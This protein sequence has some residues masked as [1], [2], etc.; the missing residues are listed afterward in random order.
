MT[1]TSPISVDIADGVAHVRLIR[2]DKLNAMNKAFWRDLPA[3]IRNI[4]DNARARVIVISSEGKH[5]SSGMDL[6]VFAEDPALNAPATGDTTVGNE[7]FR[8]LVA[9]LQDSFSALDEAR[10]PVLAAIQGGCIGGAV[11]MVSACD[12]RYATADAF[13]QIHEINIGMTADVGTFPRLCKLLPDGALRELAYTGRRLGAQKALALG[14]VTEVYPDQATMLEA[15]MATAREIASKAPLAIAGTKMMINYARDHTIA[16]GLD[17]IALWQA[18][19]HSRAAM[20]EAF[21]AQQDKR[22][23]VYPDLAPLR[24]EL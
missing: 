21:R 14:L 3:L 13:F 11:D 5:F 7:A 9:L 20:A 16:E 8:H 15:V 17:R 18:G 10:M 24:K 22:T 4:S 12:I 19:M 2:P 23:P 1:E 6:S